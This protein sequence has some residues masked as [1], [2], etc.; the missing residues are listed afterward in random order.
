M[1]TN[2]RQDL[3]HGRNSIDTNSWNRPFS[4]NQCRFTIILGWKNFS[5]QANLLCYNTWTSMGSTKFAVVKTDYITVVCMDEDVYCWKLDYSDK[6]AVW[7]CFFQSC[8][9]LPH[10]YIII[11]YCKQLECSTTM[12][13]GKLLVRKAVLLLQL[14]C[15]YVYENFLFTTVN[16]YCCVMDY[17]CFLSAEINPRKLC[18]RFTQ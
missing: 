4:L 17:L 5:T 10:Q 11:G 16:D 9:I 14:P 15:W 8:F 2:R 7:F 1:P 6:S 13:I 3:I 18:L 12:L